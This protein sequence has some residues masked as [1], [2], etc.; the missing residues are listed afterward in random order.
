MRLP[1][2]VVFLKMAVKKQKQNAT[3]ANKGFAVIN[4][5]RQNPPK[6]TLTFALAADKVNNKF[7][8]EKSNP[9]VIMAQMRAKGKATFNFPSKPP[10][11]VLISKADP[12]NLAQFLE[13]IRKILNGEN[14]DVDKVK[15]KSSDFKP[16]TIH[17]KAQSDYSRHMKNASEFLKVLKIDPIT[18][19]M[20][21][22]GWMK[23]KNLATL[24]LSGNPIT[25]LKK[26]L[27]VFKSLPNLEV[28][29]LK[30]CELGALSVQEIAEMFATLSK[31]VTSLDLSEN[32]LKIFP[33]CYHLCQLRTLNLANNLL[34]YVP[35]RIVHFRN[36]SNFNVS[37]NQIRSLPHI[38]DKFSNMQSFSLSGNGS[39]DQPLGPIEIMGNV[40]R[41]P[42]K[43]DKEFYCHPGGVDTLVNIAAN[44]LHRNPNHL[45]VARQFLPTCLRF[46]MDDLIETELRKSA[47]EVCTQCSLLRHIRHINIA[48]VESQSIANQVDVINRRVI[49][50]RLLCID[51]F[52][53]QLP[54]SRILLVV[55]YFNYT[56]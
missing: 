6:Y 43:L 14:V 51:C 45:S 46:Q 49:C 22:T 20:P 29:E 37:H 12:E 2:E 44:A 35:S 38:F 26:N 3:K 25:R 19:R 56:V 27:H 11:S 41:V 30:N 32:E 34:K 7:D 16:S 42:T 13:L 36:L 15:I 10:I 47:L 21:D 53:P 23:C 55:D 40:C 9:P 28:L 48:S 4:K 50:E 33:P 8:L 52:R 31:S 54:P 17:I 24:V 18:M 5:L 1:C 39:L